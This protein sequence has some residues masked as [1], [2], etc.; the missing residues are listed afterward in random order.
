MQ[1]AASQS[2]SASKL[3]FGKVV[4][5]ALAP[6]HS[7][8]GAFIR[9]A[10]VHFVFL[11]LTVAAG[12]TLFQ[13]AS[14]SGYSVSGLILFIL[15]YCFAIFTL[16]DFWVNWVRGC[17]LGREYHMPVFSSPDSYTAPMR[18]LVAKTFWRVLLR[19]IVI[20]LFNG[21]LLSTSFYL[22]T[23]QVD[24]ILTILFS[25]LGLLINVISVLMVVR[26]SISAAATAIMA[27]KRSFGDALAI[28][29]GHNWAVVGI[30]IVVYMVRFLVLGLLGMGL[31]GLSLIDVGSVNLG[32]IVILCAM[33]FLS[34]AVNGSLIVS[35][36]K[37]FAPE[38]VRDHIAESV[39][40]EH[41][42]LGPDTV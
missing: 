42:D 31:H 19:F 5:E 23:V 32:L 37:A 22:S 3:S 26:L 36:Y 41:P 24:A 16:I 21:I 30:S 7:A 14:V 11:V 27:P 12:V 40:G 4:G 15:L 10:S 13:R 34:F 17:A 39:S 33:I 2:Q 38:D 6:L 20:G 9:A 35:L 8:L 29:A 1:S 18:S 28:S 25:L